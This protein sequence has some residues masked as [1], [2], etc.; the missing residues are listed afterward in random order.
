MV[1]HREADQIV[2]DQMEG[3]VKTV[4]V[5]HSQKEKVVERDQDVASCL[6]GC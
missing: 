2:V 1:S 3:L 5:P 4:V 6:V